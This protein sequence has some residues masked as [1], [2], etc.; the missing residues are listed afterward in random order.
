VLCG[1]VLTADCLLGL[2]SRRVGV[3]RVRDHRAWDQSGGARSA[4]MGTFMVQYVQHGCSSRN[5]ICVWALLRCSRFV[6]T[7]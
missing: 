5:T 3:E 2:D 6:R 4:W 1:C 7:S